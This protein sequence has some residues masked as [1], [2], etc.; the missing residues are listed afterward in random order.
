MRTTEHVFMIG[1]AVLIGLL[2]GFGAIGFRWLIRFIQE[3]AHPDWGGALDALQQIP[4]YYKLVIPAAGGAIVGPLV[5]FGA[6]EAK[7]H[8]VPEVMEA[9]ALRGGRIRSRVVVVKSL[10]S[11]LSIGS[12]MSVGREGPIAQIGSAIGSTIGQRLKVNTHRLR[13]FVGCGAAAGIAATFNAPIAGAFFA[14][15]IIL[16]DFALVQFSPIVIASVIAT[17]ISRQYLGD[18]PAFIVPP[19]TLT[20]PVE[21]LFYAVLGVL[22]AVIGV[23]FVKTLYFSEDRFDDIPIPD[24]VKP[25]LG[26]LSVGVIGL[27]YPHIYGVGY[28]AIDEA[29]S[30]VMAWQLLVVL[31]GVKILATSITLGAGGSG[32]VFAPSLFVGSMAGG[33]FGVMVNHLW[34]DLSGGSGAYAL[35]A[36]GAVVS[37]TTRAP[38]TSILIIFELTNDY[39]LILPLMISCILSTLISAYLMKP[40]IYTLKLLR[41]G[42]DVHKGQEVNILRALK[43]GDARSNDFEAISPRTRLDELFVRLS[44]SGHSEF[45]VVDSEKQVQ[46]VVPFDHIRNLLFDRDTPAGAIVA[47][48]LARTDLPALTDDVTLDRVMLLFGQ[49]RVDAFPVVDRKNRLIGVIDREHVMDAYNREAARRDLAGEFNTMVSALGTRQIVELGDNYAMVEIEAPQPFVGHSI[50]Q[51]RV[52]AKYGVQILLIKHPGP[53]NGTAH[54]VPGPDYVIQEDDVLLLAGN[55]D[56]IQRA[57]NL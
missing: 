46:G 9:V 16:G 7:G 22:T 17:A 15:E 30:G 19:H 34:P 51:L 14:L 13:T 43:V 38:I 53:P 23:V 48:D 47:Y 49:Y 5:Y 55:N 41:R 35:V 56:R 31:V 29:L 50:R 26:G 27:A 57:R 40:S 42:V 37:A 52:R 10:A 20:H 6:R 2:G 54:F 11:A 3:M 39:K 32:G 33:A 25:I 12:G 21:L 1:V 44:N 36:M 28:E 18:V 4:W 45:Y 24:Y 8:G